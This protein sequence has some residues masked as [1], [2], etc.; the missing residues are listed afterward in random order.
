VVDDSVTEMSFDSNINV[1]LIK[2]GLLKAGKQNT[3]SILILIQL[4]GQGMSDVV[5]GRKMIE[6]R[7]SVVFR[8][9]VVVTA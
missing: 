4:W 1:I 6:Y 8:L 3:C 7:C 5:S 2:C 9:P